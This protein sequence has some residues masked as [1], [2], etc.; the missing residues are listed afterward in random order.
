MSLVGALNFRYNGLDL[1]AGAVRFTISYSQPATMFGKSGI[2]TE[3][4][5]IVGYVRA[6]TR[7]LLND[8]IAT[9]EAAFRANG[10]DLK[11]VDSLGTVTNHLLL[12]SSTLNGNNPV[13]FAWIVTPPTPGEFVLRRSFRLRVVGQTAPL[14]YSHPLMEWHESLRYMGTGGSVVKWRPSLTGVP[15]AQIVQV[16]STVTVIQRGTA[17]GIGDYPVPPDPYFPLFLQVLPSSPIE[18]VTPR[19]LGSVPTQYR[20]NWLWVMQGPAAS[21]TSTTEPTLPS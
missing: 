6:T 19:T 1:P 5:D 11:I 10:G 12:N 8:A 13:Q 9:V 16:A 18:Y 14:D 7:D 21:L 15:M 2:N 20:V 17:L 4:W 3:I